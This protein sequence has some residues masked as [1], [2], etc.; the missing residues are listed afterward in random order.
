MNCRTAQFA[1]MALIQ[2]TV[3]WGSGEGKNRPKKGHFDPKT[4]KKCAGGVLEPPKHPKKIIYYIYYII[5]YILYIIYYISYII[6]FSSFYK[7]FLEMWR[8]F[9]S[10][11]LA[12]FWTSDDP[13]TPWTPNIILSEALNVILDHLGEPPSLCLRKRGRRCLA[14]VAA[15][16]Q[17]LL[18]HSSW[19]TGKGWS[20]GHCVA[21]PTT[22]IPYILW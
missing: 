21:V 19:T 3:S 17:R 9:G 8:F 6:Y 7:W 22:T 14:I 13:Y 11:F 1:S 10:P 16:E 20:F 5:Y 15:P 12:D 2:L 18:A 4:A